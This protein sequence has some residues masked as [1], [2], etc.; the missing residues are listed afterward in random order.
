MASSKASLPRTA[1][2]P[3]QC[4]QVLCVRLHPC[5][6]GRA[7]PPSSYMNGLHSPLWQPHS[8]PPRRC[9]GG[10]CHPRK[11]GLGLLCDGKQWSWCVYQIQI[12]APH[13]TW[14]IPALHWRLMQEVSSC[15][16]PAPADQE[17]PEAGQSPVLRPASRVVLQAVHHRPDS[18]VLGSR[19]HAWP[20]YHA[21]IPQ[22]SE[23]I[24]QSS[25]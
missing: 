7:S 14:V 2:T 24:E 25:C 17:S 16:I 4:P 18:A 9:L 23:A 13:I 10:C 11:E 5:P 21:C 22:P 19:P 8:F 12:P 1:R 6:R 3:R 15:L 20:R